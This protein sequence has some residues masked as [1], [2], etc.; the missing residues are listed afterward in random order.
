MKNLLL[1]ICLSS[2]LAQEP[3]KA[4]QDLLNSQVEQ[5]MKSNKLMNTA[6]IIFVVLVI[7]VVIAV[8]IHAF[9]MRV[10]KQRR[11]KE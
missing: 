9:F 10:K 11:A 1:L 7:V 2:T 4:E 3:S 6:I 5:Y 8:F